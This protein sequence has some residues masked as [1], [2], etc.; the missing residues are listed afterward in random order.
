M[1]LIKQVG[2]LK[3]VYYEASDD[4]KI[5]KG[6]ENVEPHQIMRRALREFKRHVAEET[7]GARKG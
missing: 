3:L 6:K 4:F 7:R 1:K 5:W 2:D